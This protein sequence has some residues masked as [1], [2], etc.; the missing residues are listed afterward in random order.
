MPTQKKD[1]ATAELEFVL[2]SAEASAFSDTDFFLWLRES[3]L[4]AEAAIR[5]KSL[6]EATVE[7]GGRVIE[8]GRL[9]LVKLIEFVNAN[10]NLATGAAL[11]A[12]IAVLISGVPLIGPLL[13]PIA[14]ILGVSI[15]AIAGHRLDIKNAD[16]NV[17]R[18]NHPIDIGQDL[19]E[20]AAAFFSL[21]IAIFKIVLAGTETPLRSDEKKL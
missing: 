16:A 2:L 19:I 15:G 17:A 12:G 21:L 14:T 6:L 13:A 9:I 10:K 20:V 18:S 7:V 8:I 4:S 5:L 3:G 1:A 11:G